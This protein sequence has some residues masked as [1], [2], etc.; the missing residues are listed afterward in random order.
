MG[1]SSLCY[2]LSTCEYSQPWLG[3]PK[4]L[5]EGV[6]H[7]YTEGPEQDA[8]TKVKQVPKNLVVIT[9]DGCWRKSV[10]WKKVGAE[11]CFTSPSQPRTLKKIHSNPTF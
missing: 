7:E 9:F 1:A 10:N 4:F 8:W 5:V 2:T 6:I 3:A 11:V